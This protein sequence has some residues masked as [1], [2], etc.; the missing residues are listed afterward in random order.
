MYELKGLLKKHVRFGRITQDQADAIIAKA[1]VSEHKLVLSKETTISSEAFPSI[2]KTAVKYYLD[3]FHDTVTIQHLIPY[4]KGEKACTDVLYL[5]I[6]KDLPYST[7]AQQVTHMIHLEGYLDT[8]LLYAAMEYFGI[9][10]YLV[11]LDSDYHGE[12][13]NK[14][15]AYDMVAGKE[16]ERDFTLKLSMADLEAFRNQSQEE[17]EKNLQCVHER[18]NMVTEI[19]D[20]RQ[21]KNEINAVMDDVFAKHVDKPFF[22]EAM[23]KEISVM[24]ARLIAE[25]MIDSSQIINKNDIR[26]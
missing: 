23:A 1:S 8:K 5:Y 26:P 4:V 16:V 17:Y 10:F 21:R 20:K 2:V 7:D 25:R 15:Y 18:A 22:T 14:T 19:W 13:I 24:A 12:D 3:S 11:V 9:Y 6:L